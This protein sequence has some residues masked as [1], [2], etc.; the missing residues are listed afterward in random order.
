MKRLLAILVLAPVLSAQVE[1]PSPYRET[2]ELRWAS[3]A[4]GGAPFVYADPTDPNREIGFEVD[5]AAAIAD[6]LGV[7]MR[8]VQTP[9]EHLVEGLDRGDFDLVMNGFE[10]TPD[11]LPQVAFTRP[12]YIFQQQ[13]SVPIDSKATSLADCAGHRV[14]CL[15]QSASHLV[16]KEHPEIE[17]VVYEDPTMIYV[18]IE[19]GRLF[20]GLADLPIAMVMTPR[21]PRVRSAG[22]PF[23]EFYYAI[24]VR[25]G[26]RD[27]QR[28]VDGA[29]A[30]LYADGSLERIYRKWNLWHAIEEHLGDPKLL[31]FVDGATSVDA[32]PPSTGARAS[33]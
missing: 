3:D 16:L 28:A 18:D 20:A 22:E 6:A 13:L 7:R 15:G 5:L 30:G 23:G 2:G 33:A 1:L 31:S 10:P 29:I 25:K 24:A 11:R 26:E 14:G 8:R 32:H 21:H 27:L 12:Y 9:W 4:E 17:A 19:N